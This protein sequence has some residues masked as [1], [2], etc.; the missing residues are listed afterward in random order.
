[1]TQVISTK[2]SAHNKR[3]QPDKVPA[4]IALCRKCGKLG[5][6]QAMEMETRI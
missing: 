3:M 2:L 5:T 4:T 1:M 6:N